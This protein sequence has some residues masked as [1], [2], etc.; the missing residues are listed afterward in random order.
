M[1]ANEQTHC[2]L[3]DYSR[4]FCPAKVKHG[5]NTSTLQLNYSFEVSELKLTRCSYGK[6]QTVCNTPKYL[7]A[8]GIY[9]HILHTLFEPLS[10]G[11]KRVS[12]KD[13]ETGSIRNIDLII[14]EDSSIIFRKL[15]WFICLV[16]LNP[17]PTIQWEMH[18]FAK[19]IFTFAKWQNVSG[20]FLLPCI[21]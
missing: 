1:R 17:C 15:H 20:A 12:L 4:P 7:I 19:L 8:G 16:L 13:V 3:L 14:H 10:F 2:W 18:Q 6:K 21:Y 5:N 9:F 11:L